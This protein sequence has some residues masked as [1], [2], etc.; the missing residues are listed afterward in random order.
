MKKMFKALIRMDEMMIEMLQ[1]LIK[2]LE[3]DISMLRRM[4][5]ILM[6]FIQPIIAMFNGEGVSL[7]SC[8]KNIK[9][10]GI[11]LL[12]QSSTFQKLKKAWK[13]KTRPVKGFLLD[14]F[15]PYTAM[16]KGDKVSFASCN[17]NLKKCIIG[18]F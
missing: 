14:A 2:M 15:T 6:D 10:C 5:G 17:E 18:L 12:N 9:S 4:I 1:E 16:F 11:G 7:S 13:R 3:K 8:I